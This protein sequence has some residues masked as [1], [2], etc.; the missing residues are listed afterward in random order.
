MHHS[1]F[2]AVFRITALFVSSLIVSC[3][4]IDSAQAPELDHSAKWVVLP[5]LNHTETPQAGLRAEAILEGLLR[6]NRLAS[7]LERYPAALDPEALWDP[8]DQRVVDQAVRWAK[9]QHAAYGITGTVDE[10]RYKV[11]VDGEPVVGMSLRVIDLQSDTV[12]WGGVGARTGWAR[13]GLAGAAQ[14][15]MRD[16][17][18]H[19]DLI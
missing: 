5:M 16:L 9:E 3:S 6:S 1:Q 8:S 15:L 17:L 14:K 13:E 10:W 18:E 4:V 12:V 11:G 2:L 19:A 7:H